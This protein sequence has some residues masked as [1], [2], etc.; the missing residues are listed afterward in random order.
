VVEEGVR[1]VSLEWI[2]VGVALVS[3]VVS[4]VTLVIAL[5][6]LGSTRRSEQTGDER[7]EMLREQR[8]RLEFLHEER[9]LLQEQLAEERRRRG[10]VAE[11]YH[12]AGEG[13]RSEPS[14]E[15][16]PGGPQSGVE[17]PRRESPETPVQRPEGEEVWL[18]AASSQEDAQRP[19]WRR[20]F[21]G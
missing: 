6:I 17:E 18:D 16:P 21:G 13:V 19:W 20:M 8:E 15:A 7:L 9:R 4:L 5:L 11:G 3:L 2:A 12:S 1:G 10:A 14:Q